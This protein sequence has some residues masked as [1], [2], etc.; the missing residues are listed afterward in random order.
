MAV[1]SIGV[2]AIADFLGFIRSEACLYRTE[3]T[4]SLSR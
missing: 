1:D 4:R 2:L 3:S